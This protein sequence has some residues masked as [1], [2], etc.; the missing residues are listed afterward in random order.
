MLSEKIHD[1]ALLCPERVAHRNSESVLTYASL[2][3]ASN[4]AALWLHEL[5][6][7]RGIARQTPV[8]VYG[9]KE[10]E[11]LVLFIACVKAGHPYIPVDSS[12]PK[13]RLRQ[14]IEASGAQLVLSP[15]PVPEGIAST[16]VI[17]KDNIL[18]GKQD[19]IL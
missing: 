3:N 11:M 1:W 17:I 18:L 9:H 8:V 19:S 7:A 12:V 15:Q 16:Q 13:E 4:A 14:I 2:E 10:N 5:C 6:E